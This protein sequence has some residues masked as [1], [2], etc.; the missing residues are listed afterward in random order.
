MTRHQR[1]DTLE[2]AHQHGRLDTLVSPS[3]AK[4]AS[5][6]LIGRVA[7]S[8]A[9]AFV[10][11]SIGVSL[12]YCS[13]LVIARIVGVET[14]GLYAYVLAWMVV[15]TYLSTLGFEIG[16]LRFVPAYETEREWRRLKGV[17]QYAHRRVTLVS[18]SVSLIG[19]GVVLSLRL[20]PALRDTFLT[21]FALVPVLALLFIRCSVVRAFGGVVS[22]VAPDRVVRDGV[23]IGLLL[24]PFFLGWGMNAPLVMAA[25]LFSAAVGLGCASLAMY[26]YR[27]RFIAH[28]AADYDAPA[29][30][31]AVLPLVVLGAVE[32]LLNRTGVI[33]LGWLAD[34]KSA[35]IYSLVFNIAFV[36]ALPRLAVNTLFAP[37]V[38]SLYARNDMQ[39]MQAL[40]A[41]AALWTLLAGACIG[42]VLFVVAEPFLSWFGPGYEAGVPALR[43]LLVGQVLAAA[44]GSQLFVMTMTGQERTAAVLLTASTVFN[45]SVS[46]G[47]VAL[48][49]LEGAAIG[50]AATLIVWNVAMAIS[51]WRRLGLRT[52]VFG[53]Y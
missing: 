40:V 30:R 11:Y 22:A 2:V 24:V 27:P 19:V 36:V 31:R 37:T 3:D 41:Q 39:T 49:G 44:A 26:R 45:A 15:L 9:A 34:T 5:G 4:G 20:S 8:G 51:L 47:L 38:S 29:W 6:A 46:A 50:T 16:L 12:T 52:G 17:V 33:L 13:Q 1:R 35:G 14:Y 48:L 28:V 21:G 32:A 7:R 18:I 43:I 23:L 10:V 42:I 53:M 25:T